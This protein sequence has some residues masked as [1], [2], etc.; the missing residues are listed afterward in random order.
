MPHF[1]TPTPPESIPTFLKP[2]SYIGATA[3]ASG[4]VL[5]IWLSEA[6][7]TGRPILSLVVVNSD[8]PGGVDFSVDDIPA[9]IQMLEA[10]HGSEEVR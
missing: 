7:V 8:D 5:G 2:N 10:V 1:R 6:A 9:I 4:D 3:I